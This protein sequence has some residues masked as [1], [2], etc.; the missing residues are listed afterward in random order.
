MTPGALQALTDV[1]EFDGLAPG[2]AE[3]WMLD[4]RDR[5]VVRIFGLL[6]AVAEGPIAIGALVVIVL[7]ITQ[8]LWT[9]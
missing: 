3:V 4:R 6:G 9:R 1:R 8:A 7:L 5:L 2:S